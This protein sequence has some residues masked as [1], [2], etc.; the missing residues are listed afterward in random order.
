MAE[1]K[2]KLSQ[3]QVSDFVQAA[4][5]SECDIDIFHNRFVVDAKS[6]L[7][8]LSLDLTQDLTVRTS[9]KDAEFEQRIQKYALA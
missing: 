1:Y 9:M 2:I 3:S 5:N 8:V 6:I 4:G 7:G